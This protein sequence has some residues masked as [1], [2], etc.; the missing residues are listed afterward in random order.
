MLTEPFDS[1]DPA[2]APRRPAERSR[3]LS[4]RLPRPLTPIIGRLREIDT[5]RRLLERPDVRLLTLT[6]PAGVGKTRLAL[7]VAAGFD[8][9][10]AFADGVSYVALGAV[11]N[12]ALVPL[13]IAST[14]GVPQDAGQPI[15]GSLQLAL[16]DRDELILFD[17]FEH[18]VADAPLL[19]NLLTTCPGITLLVTSRERLRLSGEHEF[20]VPTLELPPS[21]QRETVTMVTASDAVTLF[22]ERARAVAPDFALTDDS[23]PAVAE[24]CRRLDGLPLAIELA[25][26][27]VKILPLDPLLLRMERRLPL[28]TGGR[29]DQPARLRTMRDAIA[30]SYDILTAEDQAMCRRLSVFV[31]GFTL[32][33]AERVMGNGTWGLGDGEWGMGNDAR[34]S[35]ITLDGISSLVEKSLVRQV[36]SAEGQGR[37]AMLETV[38]E[39]CAEQLAAAGEED[40]ARR[41]HAEWVRVLAEMA[42]AALTGPDQIAWLRTLDTEHDNLRAALG[43]TI[44]RGDAETALRIVGALWRFWAYRGAY[45][46]G[47]TWAERALNAPGEAPPAVRASAFHHLGNL[48][49][50][51]GDLAVTRRYYEAGH[52]IRRELGDPVAEAVSLNGLGLVAF[53]HGD[54]D[55]A[56]RLHSQ[57][58]AIRREH[59]ELLGTSNSLSNLGDVATASGDFAKSRELQEAART[60]R[61]TAGDVVAAAYSTFNLGEVAFAEGTLDEAREHFA[62][63][64]VA[65]IETGDRLGVAY[66]RC[67]M[68]RLSLAQG[69]APQAAS[70]LAEAL[71]IRHEVG[72]RRGVAECLEGLADVAGATGQAAAAI[73]LYSAAEALRAVI[74]IPIRLYD[75]ARHAQAVSR[76]RAALPREAAD[77]AWAGGSKLT[78]DEATERALAVAAAVPASAERLEPAAPP[79]FGSLSARE[80]DVLRLIAAGLSNREIGEELYIAKRTV[81]TH[82]SNIFGKLGLS[83]R[84]EAAAFAIRNGLA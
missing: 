8:R 59:G 79:S 47:R 63:S 9:E 11:A 28:L 80:A 13:T 24:I 3:A 30:W 25:A 20:S 6:G 29:R 10:R 27:R 43:W 35:P 57:A 12:P 32:D 23:A 55:E 61:R 26:A 83:S 18:V 46:E 54:Y 51:V 74:E 69:D 19:A 73:E 42:D 4:T 21:R 16:R 60:I 41:L 45:A 5:V 72:D 40:A 31:G 58:H 75:R 81:D 36:E 76:A 56:R 34:P 39:F 49:L 17:N 44:D 68:G 14:L 78:P 71:A 70:L 66:T 67:E 22:V 64:L 82:V 37:F 15:E 48:T 1:R 62:Q 33:A 84:A 53:Y 2:T 77:R 7:E 38:R 65:F 50:D 52:E